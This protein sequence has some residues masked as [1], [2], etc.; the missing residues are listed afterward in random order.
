M[1]KDSV[2][3]DLGDKNSTLAPGEDVPSPKADPLENKT[4]ENK[5]CPPRGIPT[6]KSRDQARK[7]ESEPS[8]ATEPPDSETPDAEVDDDQTPEKESKDHGKEKKDREADRTDDAPKGF[9]ERILPIILTFAGVLITAYV[10]LASVVLKQAGNPVARMSVGLGDKTIV[11]AESGTIS[12]DVY[13]IPVDEELSLSS[14]GSVDPDGDFSESEM[15]WTIYQTH[16]Q[17]RLVDQ[18]KVERLSSDAN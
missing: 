1:P 5:K 7:V 18:S 9:L 14:A 17:V 3:D 4:E 13:I 8:P 2:E 6:E 10:T 16:P 15:E 11:S 12:K